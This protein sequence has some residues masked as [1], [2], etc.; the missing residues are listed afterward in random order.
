MKQD[1]QSICWKNIIRNTCFFTFMLVSLYM[2]LAREMILE[3]PF[4]VMPGSAIFYEFIPFRNL[5]L[6]LTGPHLMHH[7]QHNLSK[8]FVAIGFNLLFMLKFKNK[9]EAAIYSLMFYVAAEA[10]HFTLIA[11][12]FLSQRFSYSFN[13]DNLIYY[14]VG[15]FIAYGINKALAGIK[16]GKRS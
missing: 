3:Y 6:E 11:F 1:L 4:R 2:Y 5:Y 10:V 9:A 15:I 14:V 7:L 8:I 13:I 16:H 12:S